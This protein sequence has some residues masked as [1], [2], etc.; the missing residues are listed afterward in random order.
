MSKGIT[1]LN[2]KLH[3][4]VNALF[5]TFIPT[6][7]ATLA[8]W[9]AMG[10]WHGSS[11]LYLFYGLYYFAIMTIGTCLQ[12][13]HNKIYEKSKIKQNSWWLVGL[14]M[15]RTFVLVN[16]GMLLFRAASIPAAFS[17]FGSIFSLQCGAYLFDLIPLHDFILA[18]IG[19]PL[20]IGVDVLNVKNIYVIQKLEKTRAVVRY[21]CIL[22]L[23]LA[24]LIFGAYGVGYTVTDAL[25]GGF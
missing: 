1:K 23:L 8:V 12:P 25:Y 5:E 22:A 15:L 20:L 11:W 18:V 3:G 17:M 9:V 21:L 14:R 2:K 16:I 19:T 24:V 7:I 13:L 4:K 10:M 6:T